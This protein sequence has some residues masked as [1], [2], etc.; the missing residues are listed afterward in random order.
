[1]AKLKH[2]S[3]VSTD[4]AELAM[5][6]FKNNFDWRVKVRG[7]GVAVSDFTNQDQL[8]FD[9]DTKQQEKKEN[10]EQTVEMLRKRYGRAAINRAVVLR[11][12]KF[13][14]LDIKDGHAG[15][16]LGKK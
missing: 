2:P 12:D 7:L 9:V 6:M 4:I 14:C 3:N 8:S 1:M 13:A 10:L 16:S 15:S 11:E 5:E